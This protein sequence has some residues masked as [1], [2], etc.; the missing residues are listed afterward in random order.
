MP[1]PTK[2]DIQSA[3]LALAPQDGK[4]EIQGAIS[5]MTKE[6]LALMLESM[7]QE[8]GIAQTEEGA[9][10]AAQAAAAVAQQGGSK[11]QVKAAAQ[12]AAQATEA[13]MGGKREASSGRSKSHSTRGKGRARKASEIRFKSKS[14]GM[15]TK[16]SQAKN[17]TVIVQALKKAGVQASTR[18]TRAQLQAKLTQANRKKTVRK[19]RDGAKLPS[20]PRA[21][22]VS[23][24]LK[25]DYNR[26]R[27]LMSGPKYPLSTRLAKIYASGKKADGRLV[28]TQQLIDKALKPRNLDSFKSAVAEERYQMFLQ[29]YKPLLKKAGY[30]TARGTMGKLTKAGRRMF[31]TAKSK[32]RKKSARK[33]V[34]ARYQ[35][36][37][38]QGKLPYYLAKGY[39]RRIGGGPGGPGVVRVVPGSGATPFSRLSEAEKRKVLNYLN[40]DNGKSLRGKGA[41]RKV[42]VQ[43]II[44]LKANEKAAKQQ[45]RRRAKAAAQK[46]KAAKGSSNQWWK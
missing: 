9:Q 30:S 45:A 23:P 15:T 12:A 10:A 20:S 33:S 2:K 18:M 24:A 36:I 21:G 42:D 43:G 37:K 11:R 34:K 29:F 7:Q 26:V 8:E 17:K 13:A 41:K 39:V 27:A 1:T 3:I 19:T 32:S 46:R 14:K 4:A 28:V 5:S 16:A 22:G 40:T 44:N 25:K 35:A 6:Q 31:S 38:Q